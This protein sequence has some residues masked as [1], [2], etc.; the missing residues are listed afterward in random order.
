[1]GSGVTEAWPTTNATSPDGV[2]GAQQ[3]LMHGDATFF[4]GGS[5]GHMEDSGAKNDCIIADDDLD[6]ALS[7]LSQN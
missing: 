4:T 6:I 2:V 3:D 5:G 1:M 7:V